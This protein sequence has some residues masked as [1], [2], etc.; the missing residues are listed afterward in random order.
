MN[1][2]I[3]FLTQILIKYC[4]K[5]N[6]VFYIK[7]GLSTEVFLV[8][9]I[10]FKTRFG[11][12]YIHRFLRSDIDSPHD[13]P[14]NFFTYIVKGSYTEAFYDKKKPTSYSLWSKTKNTRKQGSLAF[15]NATDVHTVIID[16]VYSLEEIDQAPL[17]LCLIGPRK[18]EWGFWNHDGATFTDWR[19]ALNIQPGDPRIEGSE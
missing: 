19:R 7:G 9:Y 8:R 15:R 18:R 5:K 14:W 1:K 11:H 3:Q 17:T 13:H 12:L 16:K 10:V 2:I 6:K 4:E